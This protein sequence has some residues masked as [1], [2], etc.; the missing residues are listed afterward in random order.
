MNQ[1]DKPL[2]LNFKSNIGD[3][4]KSKIRVQESK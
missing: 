2:L 4:I 1:G 3:T